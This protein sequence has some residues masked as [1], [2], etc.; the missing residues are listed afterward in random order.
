MVYTTN[1]AWHNQAVRNDDG[2]NNRYESANSWWLCF[3][4]RVCVNEP[5]FLCLQFRQRY[6]M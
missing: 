4:N 6:Y 3:R 5:G 1:Q 2:A